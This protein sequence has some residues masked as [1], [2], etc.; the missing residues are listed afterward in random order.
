MAKNYK[1]NLAIIIG[2]NYIFKIKLQENYYKVTRNL[3]K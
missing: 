1:K 2:N 3:P